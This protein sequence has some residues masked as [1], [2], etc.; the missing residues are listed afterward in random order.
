M[1]ERQGKLKNYQVKINLKP[2][3]KI[4]QQKGR[5][6][7]V[8]SKK[9]VYAEVTRLLKEG[10]I[11]KIDEIKDDVFIQPTV[12]RV[13]KDRSVKT[14]L[15]ARALNHEV[16][17]VEY[18]MPNLDNLLD[19][20][21]EKLDTEE[22]EEWFLSVDMTYAYGQVPLHQQTAKH[23][24]FQ[25]IGGKSTGRYRFITG[26]YGL[27]VMP[28]EFQK[29]MDNLLAYFSEV[30][31]FIDN[32]LIVTKGTKKEH[33]DKTWEILKPLDAAKLQLKAGKCSFAKQ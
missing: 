25:I 3:A 12:I 16:D 26:F 31:V 11:E 21:A 23:C 9:S 22:E 17:K 10:H 14:T 15:D 4:T 2:N 27:S 29:V 30:F 19:M 33:L 24:N 18:Q 7:P 1:F 20:L 6:V 32:Y 8:Q 28:T 13:N 5:R